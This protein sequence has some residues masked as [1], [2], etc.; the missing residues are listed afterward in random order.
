MEEAFK[1]AAE[2][3]T[4]VEIFAKLNLSVGEL[5]RR[6]KV[7]HE[8]VFAIVN[9]R[10]SF[11]QQFV[12]K[13]VEAQVSDEFTSSINVGICKYMVEKFTNENT[14]LAQA[15]DIAILESLSS[16][17]APAVN[18]TREQ[19]TSQLRALK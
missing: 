14:T 9:G 5:R 19:V 17:S 18:M 7:D 10:A 16:L 4:N 3:H 2:G 8:L 6:I 11:I 15:Y 1:L 13:L 12:D